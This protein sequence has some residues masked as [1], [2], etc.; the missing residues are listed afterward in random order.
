VST[1][2]RRSFLKTTA[3]G[4]GGL[5]LAGPLQGFAAAPAGARTAR[6]AHAGG[7]H[8]NGNGN[9]DKADD[10]GPLSPATDRATGEKLLALPKDV[11]YWALSQ[12]GAPMSDGRPTP[13]AHDGM[14]AFE[15][16][17]KIR[18]VR[19]HE[20]RGAAPAFGPS[21]LA[22]DTGAGGGNTIIEFDPRRPDRPRVF[23]TLSGASTDCCGGPTPWGRG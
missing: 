5:A 7:G 17:R 4:G 20:V 23:G 16:G 9:G 6:G 2:G 1:L 21:G 10:D 19:N 11:K 8:G 14:A 13:P 22:Y 18:V 12:V 15:W 3:A